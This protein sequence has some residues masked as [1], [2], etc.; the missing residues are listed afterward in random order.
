MPLRNQASIVNVEKLSVIT[1]YN[2]WEYQR[3]RQSQLKDPAFLKL[4]NGPG[5]NTPVPPISNNSNNQ[6]IFYIV[7]VNIILLAEE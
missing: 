4:C 2:M 3:K 5:R 6:I 7:T 1:T